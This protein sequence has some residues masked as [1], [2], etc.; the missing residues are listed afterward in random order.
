[1]ANKQAYVRKLNELIRAQAR[2]EQAVVEGSMKLLAELHQQLIM[3]LTAVDVPSFAAHQI[4]EL[5][6]NTERLMAQYQTQQTAVLGEGVANLYDTG[7]RAEYEPLLS[8]G[9]EA[10]FY[11]PNQ[12]QVGIL[13]GFSADLVKG[14]TDDLRKRLNTQIRIAALGQQSPFAVQRVVTKLLGFT[15]RGKLLGTGVAYE[16]ER[17]VRTELSRAFNAG[18]YSQQLMTVT[19]VPGL[20]KRW[21]ATGDFRTRESHLRAHAQTLEKPIP[22]HDAFTVGGYS[23]MY[24]TDPAGPAKE[25]IM[26]RCRTQT[27]HPDI[28]II[29]SGLDSEIGAEL[30]RRKGTEA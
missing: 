1:M 23:L 17:I 20:L 13:Q 28:G 21:V 10:G 25:T 18:H 24:P 22:I 3:E 6:T 9:V 27:I 2:G 26:C 7:Q 16:A 30:A 11:A 12:V 14:L 8:A 15:P 29:E 5:L 19:A 4:N